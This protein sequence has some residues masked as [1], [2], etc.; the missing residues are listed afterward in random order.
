MQLIHQYF[1]WG[2]LNKQLMFLKV[3]EFPVVCV[4]PQEIIENHSGSGL[5]FMV[6]VQHCNT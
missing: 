4:Q 6:H 5:A 1:V 3:T 2:V